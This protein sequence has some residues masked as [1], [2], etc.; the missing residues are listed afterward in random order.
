MNNEI[1]RGFLNFEKNLTHQ[2]LTLGYGGR[3]SHS[4]KTEGKEFT[5]VELKFMEGLIRKVLSEFGHSFSSVCPMEFKHEKFETNPRFFAPS[6]NVVIILTFEVSFAATTGVFNIALP[7]N[8]IE[9]L[10]REI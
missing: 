2:L 6:T 9:K 10:R 4:I 7:Y 3:E 5:Q 1:D 8:K